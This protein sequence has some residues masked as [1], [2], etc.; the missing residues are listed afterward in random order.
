MRPEWIDECLS[1]GQIVDSSGFQVE[2]LEAKLQEAMT[3]SEVASTMSKKRKL[4]CS[5]SDKQGSSKLKPEFNYKS[6]LEDL[7][8]LDETVFEID[9]DELDKT[10]LQIHEERC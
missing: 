1:K 3:Q 2:G 5:S 7:D 10:I 4:I 6:V 8:V 9:K